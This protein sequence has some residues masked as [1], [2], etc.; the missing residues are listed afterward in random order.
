MAVYTVSTA[1]TTLFRLSRARIDHT[2]SYLLWVK[3][4]GATALNSF[5]LQ[6]R[7]SPDG[8]WQDIVVLA[9]DWLTPTTA[10]L[11]ATSTTDPTT[12]AAGSEFNACLLHR[13]TLELR[14]VATVASGSTLV[15]VEVNPSEFPIGS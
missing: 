4:S 1:E 7:N 5:K 3:N 2:G 14:I 9:A 8:V 11:E 13:Y 12:L 6:G 10:T 15:T